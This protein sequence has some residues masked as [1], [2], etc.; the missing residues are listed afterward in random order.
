MR[1]RRLFVKDT[2]ASHVISCHLTVCV[3]QLRR[4]PPAF[5]H[6]PP[7][8]TQILLANKFNRVDRMLTRGAANSIELALSPAS[9]QGDLKSMHLRQPPHRCLSTWMR[10]LPWS[11]RPD[12]SLM[13]LKSKIR[14]ECPRL[15]QGNA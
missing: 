11:K 2:D 15:P 13:P 1:M 3:S 6:R 8:S 5:L 7:E 14:R 12:I 9:T 4:E 10:K